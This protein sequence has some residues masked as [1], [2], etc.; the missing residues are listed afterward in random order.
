M[1]MQRGK[2]GVALLNDHSDDVI[3]QEVAGLAN[4]FFVASYQYNRDTEVPGDR[5]VYAEF[6]GRAPIKANIVQEPCPGVRQGSAGSARWRSG[7]TR[8][9]RRRRR[10]TGR[11]SS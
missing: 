10:S 1:K 11:S 3:T 9:W 4:G 8:G 5:R 6:S 7:R 2:R